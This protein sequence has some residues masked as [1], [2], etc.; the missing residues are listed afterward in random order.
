MILGRPVNLWNGLIIAAV[1]LVTIVIMQLRPDVD[2]EV[3]ATI[4]A[5]VTAFLGT[6][7]AFVANGTPSVLEGS[8]VN[9]VTPEGTPNRT[10]TA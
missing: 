7:I 2:S 10:I 4:A 8:D 1:S 3:V 6:A 9:V 5:A